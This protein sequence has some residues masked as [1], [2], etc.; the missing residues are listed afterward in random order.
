[1]GAPEPAQRPIGLRRVA[2]MQDVEAAA[3]ELHL[4]AQERG[5]QEAPEEFHHEADLALGVDRQRIAIDVDVLDRLAALVE[6]AHLRADD[7]D[8]IAVLRQRGG[9]EPYPPVERDRQILD[10]D[11]NAGLSSAPVHAPTSL[12]TAAASILRSGAVNTPIRKRVSNFSPRAKVPLPIKLIAGTR[13]PNS[14]EY[15]PS[16]GLSAPRLDDQASVSGSASV[17]I[18]SR[19]TDIT[20]I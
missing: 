3:E 12:D 20:A 10:H 4:E 17:A 6:A 9:F 19:S 13:S 2:D 1:E 11:Q 14:G 7:A 16:G 8:G 5:H 18:G 15:Q